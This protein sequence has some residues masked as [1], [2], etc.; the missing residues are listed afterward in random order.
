MFNSGSLEDGEPYADIMAQHTGFYHQP[1]SHLFDLV[2]EF[3]C[4]DY[5]LGWMG[6][7][8]MEAFLQNRF[9]SQ[10]MFQPGAG[11]LHYLVDLGSIE[12]WLISIVG[13]PFELAGVQVAQ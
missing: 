5:V 12:S 4:L 6:E 9:G 13:H 10:W 8:V 11:E 3:Y 1:E 7:A 2:P